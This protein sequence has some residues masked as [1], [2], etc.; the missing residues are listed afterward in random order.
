MAAY[1][2][3]RFFSYIISRKFDDGTFFLYSYFYR[4]SFFTNLPEANALFVSKLPKTPS[5]FEACGEVHGNE[6]THL[7][8]LDEL[9]GTEGITIT[10]TT[11]NR[12]HHDIKTVSV[13]AYIF[14]SCTSL[15]SL[16]G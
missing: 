12:K 11:I 14:I 8:P 10:H 16:S 7:E 1:L 5:G 15:S 3:F 6:Q 13:I 9:T 2:I 4:I